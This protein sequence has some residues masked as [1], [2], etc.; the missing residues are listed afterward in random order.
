MSVSY[1]ALEVTISDKI[2]IGLQAYSLKST[3]CKVKIIQHKVNMRDILCYH[4]YSLRAD[5]LGQGG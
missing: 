4:T 3:P 2:C 1:V 5:S